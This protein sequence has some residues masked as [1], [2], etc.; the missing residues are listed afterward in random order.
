MGDV[1]D[2]IDEGPP[3]LEGNFKKFLEQ[4]GLGN[5]PEN[6]NQRPKKS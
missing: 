2:I 4:G 1:K 5:K 6:K 3:D